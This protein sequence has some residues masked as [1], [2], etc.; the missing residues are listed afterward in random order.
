MLETFF[1]RSYWPQACNADYWN[2][3][4]TYQRLILLYYFHQKI[5]IEK[6]TIFK[7]QKP[8]LKVLHKKGVLKIFTKFTEKHLCQSPFLNNIIKNFLYGRNQVFTYY[9]HT[10]SSLEIINYLY[11]NMEISP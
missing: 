3:F 8:P 4:L 11:I 9:D 5:S 2:N 7:K 10:F 6:T 1:K